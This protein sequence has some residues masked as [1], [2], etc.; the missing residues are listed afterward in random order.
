MSGARFEG[1]REGASA[2]STD[3]RGQRVEMEAGQPEPLEQ[4]LWG[5]V[6]VGLRG[7]GKSALAPRVAA[8]LGL[9]WLD[10]DVELER[11]ERQTV[12]ALFAQ[13]GEAGFRRRERRLLLE[14][15]LPRQRTV[16]ATGGG[17]VLDA[18]VRACLT[19]RVT[20][21]LN[22][23]LSVLADRIAGSARPS[24]TGLPIAD[25]LEGLLAARE[26]LYRAVAS[27]VLDSAAA[28]PD[29][30][31]ERIADHWRTAERA[32]HAGVVR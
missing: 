4:G 14:E 29:A 1:S 15:L 6:L 5:P 13:H 24:L 27:L 28:S 11:H 7:S 21:W 16:L 30:L 32:G 19:R 17:A 31:A 9:V 23:P 20:V 12:A 22:A 18:E 2:A 8:R 26:P 10:A 3:P 25:E